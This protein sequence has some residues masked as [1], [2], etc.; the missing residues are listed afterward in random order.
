M[1]REIVECVRALKAK[2]DMTLNEIKLIIAIDDPRSR[3][4][5]RLGIE[6]RGT[7]L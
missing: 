7:A 1:C 2:R 6:V 4:N 3:Q 5:R